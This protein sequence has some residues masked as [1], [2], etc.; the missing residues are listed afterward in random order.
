MVVLTHLPPTPDD[1][2]RRAQKTP[3]E[4]P[5]RVMSVTK[6]DDG[7]VEATNRCFAWALLSIAGLVLGRVRMPERIDAAIMLRKKA[8]RLRKLAKA[9][10]PVSPELMM[11]IAAHLEDQARKLEAAAIRDLGKTGS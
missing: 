1:S 7:P 3:A 5:A 8:E 10:E 11:R 4:E 2:A 6:T 9:Q